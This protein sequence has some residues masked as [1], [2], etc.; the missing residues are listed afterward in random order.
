MRV[1]RLGGFI[2]IAT[3]NRHF[4]VDEHASW[5]RIHSPFFDDTL[6]VKE[7]ESLFNRKARTLTWKG[8]FQFER[9]GLFGAG[10][11]RAVTLFNNS[12]L[13]HSPLNPHLFLAFQK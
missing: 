10:I 12:S 1:V 3:P 5:L 11:N 7:L 6:T 8:Y 13:H 9:F 2:I 4:P